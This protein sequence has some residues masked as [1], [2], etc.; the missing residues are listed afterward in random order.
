MDN[1]KNDQYYELKLKEDLAF[2]V[3]HMKNVDKEELSNFMIIHLMPRSELQ[4]ELSL[5]TQPSASFKLSAF[6]KKPISEE[7]F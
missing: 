1:I 2:I 3:N 4:S 6:S 5:R 7:I